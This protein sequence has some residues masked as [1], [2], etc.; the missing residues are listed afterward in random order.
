[1]RPTVSNSSG[2][3]NAAR[4]MLAAA[5]AALLIAAFPKFNASGLAWVALAPLIWGSVEL[6]PKRA[7]ALS[8]L[9]GT[10]AFCGILYW[11]LPT[12][13]AARVSRAIGA[14]SL[15]LLSGYIG[16]YFGVFGAGLSWLGGH[17]LGTARGTAAAAG[18]WVALEWTRGH[19]LTGFPWGLLGYTQWQNPLLIQS[20][21]W[22]SVYGT[23]F[24]IAASGLAIAAMLRARR[25]LW[26]PALVA[27]ALPASSMLLSAT[28]RSGEAS[29]EPVRVA[30]LQGNID[31]YK[32]WDS[33]YE[34]EILESYGGLVRDLAHSEP[35]PA[36]VIWPE[37]SIPGWLPQ[38]EWLLRWTSE[39]A[40]ASGAHHLVGSVTKDGAKSH[41]SAFL[42]APDGNI[43]GRYDKI[44]LV[45]FGEF[46]PAQSVLGRWIG[47]LNEL[48]GFHAGRQ[49]DPLAVP[50]A[51]LGIGIC[52]ESIFPE[53]M[54]RQAKNGAEILVNITNDGWYLDTAAPEQHF[55]MNVFR[56]VENRRPLARAANTG[57]SGI[58]APDGTILKETPLNIRT[59]LEHAVTPADGLTFY[60]RF[61]DLFAAACA[62]G[63]LLAAVLRRRTA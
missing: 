19:F 12:F 48:G 1:M 28:Q 37:T 23:S 36:L 61:G 35:K 10:L 52:Y 4:L 21:Q 24:A 53:L 11:I 59:K 39:Q 34:R 33:E 49:F 14:L 43:V 18:L 40:R 30:L 3:I 51:K 20:A 17:A 42:F 9:S 25:W 13:D 62:A 41:N 63:A 31:Q 29:R 26:G 38:E 22:T 16:L 46:V 55:A 32:K 56:A 50:G 5:T 58:I 47:V 7:F 15:V 44:H 57:I 27:L 54:R 60:T 6:N 2:R 8:W 45:P